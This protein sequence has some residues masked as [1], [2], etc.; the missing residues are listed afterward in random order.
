MAAKKPKLEATIT[1]YKGFDKNLQCR[2]YQFEVGKTYE[3]TGPV[4]ACES[5]FHACENPMDVWSYYD[6]GNGNRFAK[7][8]VSGEISR[9]KDDSKIAAGRLTVTAEIG[10]PDLVR[11]AVAWLLAATKDKGKSGDSSQLAASGDYSQLAASGDYSQLAASGD[12]SQLAASG[13]YSKLAASGYSSQLAASGHY[14]QLAA[15]G[16]SSQ[17]AASGH[18]SKLAASG[19]SSQ[20][21]ASGDYSQLA[22][23]GHYSK[24]AASGHYS[25]LAASGDSSQL[26][27]SGYSSQLAASGHHSAIA[28]S[29]PGCTASAGDGGAICLAYMD[30]KRPRFAVG[31]VGEDG[32]KANTVY[33]VEAGR[34]VEVV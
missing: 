34:L 23:S 27:A 26:A 8:S 21:A 12:Y 32:I 22:A 14:S 13:H 25:Q 15:S 31:Y 10:I 20:L 30:G 6:I 1:A 9:H 24:L 17:L 33:R 19:Y 16:D 5:G 4:V 28:S 18:Y 3:H 2:G 7:V 29:A 11:D